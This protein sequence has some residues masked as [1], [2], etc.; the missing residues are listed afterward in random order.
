MLKDVTEVIWEKELS[1]F[2]LL[3]EKEMARQQYMKG[4]QALE[5]IEDRVKAAPKKEKEELQKQLEA[6]KATVAAPKTELDVYETKLNGGPPSEQVP[7]GSL[8]VTNELQKWAE[9]REIIKAFI[10]LNT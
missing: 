4:R 7:E 10:K 5:S 3:Q 8:G 2:T 1:K 6:I 9:R